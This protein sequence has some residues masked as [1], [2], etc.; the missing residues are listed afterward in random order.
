MLD[1]DGQDLYVT[2]LRI[3][4]INIPEEFYDYLK[5]AQNNRAVVA[6]QFNERKFVIFMQH[7]K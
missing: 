1:K 4:D 3:Q 6:T 5:T 2:S 7:L